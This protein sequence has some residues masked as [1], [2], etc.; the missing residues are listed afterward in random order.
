M[1][2]TKVI[3]IFYSINPILTLIIIR[4]HRNSLGTM[5]AVLS[6]NGEQEA[7][8]YGL[9][10]DTRRTSR[11]GTV[12]KSSGLI[13]NNHSSTAA[14]AAV[15]PTQGANEA[16]LEHN[17]HNDVS[18]QKNQNSDNTNNNNTPSEQNDHEDNHESSMT[19]EESHIHD[20]VLREREKAHA[21]LQATLDNVRET[22]RAMLN[23]IDVFLESTK[24]VMV[25]YTKCQNSQRNEARRLEE[26]EPDVVGATERYLQ[27]MQGMTQ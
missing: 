3:I 4:N 24:D 5:S 15:V 8:F 12:P 11:R 25:D 6:H 27:Q 23:E 10:S 2:S 22:T 16:I 1:S 17:S 18:E 9:A 13:S 26:V 21:R 19:I 7:A 20:S 14:T